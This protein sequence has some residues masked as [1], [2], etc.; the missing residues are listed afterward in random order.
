MKRIFSYIYLAFFFISATPKNTLTVHQKDGQS[1]SFGFEEKPVVT[2]DDSILII[3]STKTQLSY[4]LSLISKFSFDDREDDVNSIIAFKP[5][6]QISLD[7]Y[8]VSISGA[9]ADIIV[10]LINSEG[11]QIQSY[12]T[13]QEGSVKFSIAD[14]SK[15]TYIIVSESLTV[16]ILKK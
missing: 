10:R 7:E 13:D 2:F 4:E 8:V 1:F 15:G 6:P 9:K 11:K 3:N 5:M 12:K 14:Q 16:K